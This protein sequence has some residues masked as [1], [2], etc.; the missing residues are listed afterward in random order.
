[1]HLES[2]GC[3]VGVAE[4]ESSIPGSQPAIV[5]CRR[6]WAGFDPGVHRR[7]GR[8]ERRRSPWLFINGQHAS[9]PCLDRVAELR[10]PVTPFFSACSPVSPSYPVNSPAPPSTAPCPRSP[11]SSAQSRFSLREGSKCSKSARSTCRFR[12]RDRSFTRLNGLGEYVRRARELVEAGLA[13]GSRETAS[14]A[15]CGASR[16]PWGRSW[17]ASAGLRLEEQ[18]SE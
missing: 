2:S 16:G 13:L 10:S 15:S 12:A 14:S 17:G 9:P 11:P 8:K 7:V 6:I 1:M 18:L 5:V 3:R 4:S